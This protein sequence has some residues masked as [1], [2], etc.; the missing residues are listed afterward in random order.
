MLQR[1]LQSNL[2]RHLSDNFQISLM[3]YLLYIFH[4]YLQDG[5]WEAILR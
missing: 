4:I 3:R 1:Y 5:F 2:F